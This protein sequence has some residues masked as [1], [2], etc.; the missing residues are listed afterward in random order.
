MSLVYF[1]T[2]RSGGVLEAG[3]G[4]E[5]IFTAPVNFSYGSSVAVLVSGDANT[6]TV[7][8]IEADDISTGDNGNVSVCG[9]AVSASWVSELYPQLGD[10]ISA[11]A[12]LARD[13]EAENAE[14]FALCEVL[15]SIPQR[16]EV[17]ELVDVYSVRLAKAPIVTHTK[18][19]SRG[20]NQTLEPMMWDVEA[21]D[22][23]FDAKTVLY[24][25]VPVEFLHCHC[26]GTKEL[27][28]YVPNPEYVATKQ[29][30]AALVNDDIREYLG[31]KGVEN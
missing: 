1:S 29:I 13:I 27:V 20:S 8:P 21:S 16:L 28:S 12:G 9:E 30:I 22:I 23:N 19:F 31:K 14:Y 2:L 7:R 26:T 4:R 24:H 25:G 18:G 6:V 15:A 17:R 11:N 5:V 10:V 3:S